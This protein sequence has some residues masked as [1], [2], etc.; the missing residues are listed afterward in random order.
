MGWWG[1][2]RGLGDLVTGLGECV[3][4]GRSGGFKDIE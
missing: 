4:E 3:V 2:S 1:G